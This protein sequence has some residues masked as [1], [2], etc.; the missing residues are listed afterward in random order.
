MQTDLESLKELLRGDS[1]SFDANTLLGV[2]LLCILFSNWALTRKYKMA[3]NV[4]FI[5][6]DFHFYGLLQRHVGFDLREK[7]QIK[8]IN[9]T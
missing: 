1:Y 8:S 7:L 5:H 2:S 9:L 4:K 6:F 3:G